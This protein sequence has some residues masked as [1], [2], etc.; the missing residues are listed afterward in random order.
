MTKAT[1]VERLRYRFDNFMSKGTVAL[2]GGLALV[3][4][5]F[6]LLMAMLVSFTSIVPE[7]SARNLLEATWNVMRHT[8]DTSALSNDKGWKFRLAMLIVTFFGI[9]GVSTLIG[10]V[11]SGIDAKIENLRRGRSR[12][13]ETDHIV[14]LGWSLPVFTLVS[15]LALANANQP[16]TCIVILGEENKAQMEDKLHEVLGK[17]HRI[18]LICRTGSPSNM[19]DLGMVNIQ[20]ARSIVILNTPHDHGDVQLVKTLLAITNIPRAVPQPYHIVTQV[21]NPNSLDVIQ[22]IRGNEVEVVLVQDVL[23]RIIVQTCRQSGLSVVYMD[24]LDFDGYEIYFKA[25]PTLQGKT[26]GDALLAYNDSAVI[27]IKRDHTIVLNPPIHTQL[28]AAEQLIVISADDDKIHLSGLSEFPVDHQAIHLRK[29]EPPKAENTLILG[30][31]NHIS[32]II[33]QM[34]QYVAPGSTLTVVAEYPEAEVMCLE[35]LGIQ[36][37]T[38]HYRQGDITTRQVLEDL[39]LTTYDHVIVLCNTDIDPELADANTLVTLLYLRD[40]ANRSN[41]NFQI[42]TEMLDTQNQTLAQVARP[43]DFVL[44]KQIISL[45]LAQIAEHKDLNA[46]FTELFAS[47]GSEIYLKPVSD[48]VAL[49]RPVNFYTVVEAAKQRSESAIGYRRQV[50][51][52]NIAKSYGVVLN[53]QKDRLITFAPQDTIIVLA[54]S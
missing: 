8:I 27:G 30:W 16:D 39:N 7:E 54:E 2:I 10:I 48:Y 14:I 9:F 18:R 31:N 36:Q 22:I 20:T 47:E 11:S 49:D 53:P 37:Q 25:E 40:I 17:L 41:H 13:I 15:E 21:Q 43:D 3:C 4:L 19:A 51:A 32:N 12:V 33:Q 1:I 29:R 34:D 42:A 6:I 52:N 5:A 24:L 28:Q 23:S 26:Y 35:S 46:V 38:V 44:S 50:D 45:M